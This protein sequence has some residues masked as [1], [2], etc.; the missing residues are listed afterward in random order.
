MRFYIETY[1]CTANRSDESIIKGILR[2]KGFR[3][4]EDPASADVSII[5]TCTV[6]GTTEQRMLSRIRKLSK[7]SRS[8][9]V[10][11]CMA[12]VQED[13]IKKVAP[14][15]RILPPDKIDQV[16]DLI[17]GRELRKSRVSK[18]SLPRCFD[19]LRA[20]IAVSEGCNFSCSYCITSKARGRLRSYPIDEIISTARRALKEGAKEIQLTSQDLG[21]YGLDRGWKLQD[22]LKGLNS[23]EGDFM[24]RLGMMNPSSVKK[25]LEEIV[26]LYRFDKVYKFLHLP[27]QSGDDDILRMMN[28][29]YTAEEFV[30]MVERFRSE[31]PDITIST[32]IIVAFPGESDERFRNTVELLKR[33]KPDITNI[34]RFSPRPLTKAR[35]FDE[36]VPTDVAKERSKYLT[37]LCREISRERNERYVGRRF[38]ALVIERGKGDTYIARTSNYKPVVLKEE[39]RLGDFVDVEISS[40]R[41]TYLIGKLI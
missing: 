31:Y 18:T 21:S 10:S 36:R 30:E 15:S 26:S 41:D 24:I 37:K 17:L 39:V 32:D 4:V 11:G 16:Y 29:S 25:R 7:V 13:L 3:Q 14:E 2:S 38:R 28:R 23:I 9:I 40:A 5:L 20:P 8:L 27:V 34:T 22:L 19:D 33:V 1:G 12:S 6:I 35:L